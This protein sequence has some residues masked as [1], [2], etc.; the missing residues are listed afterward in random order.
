MHQQAISAEL[1]ARV[2]ETIEVMVDDIHAGG[3]LARSHWNAAMSI[4]TARRFSGQVTA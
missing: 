4:L 2:G 3:T 1:P